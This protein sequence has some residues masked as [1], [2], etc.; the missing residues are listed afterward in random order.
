MR[1]AEKLETVEWDFAGAKT[2]DGPH[3]IHPYPAKFIPQIPKT[4]IKLFHPGDDSP[5]LDPFCGSG[6][7][8]VEAL[9]VGIPSIGIDLNPLA[10]L[11]AKVKTTPL[12]RVVVEVAR[13]VSGRARK[14]ISLHSVK[15][16]PIPRLDH[17][18]QKPVQ[19]ALAALISEINQVGPND[20]CDALKIALSS[21][22]V[23]VSNQESDTRYAAVEKSLDSE[24][25]LK[26]FERAAIAL[27][28]A[29][30]SMEDGLFPYTPS[31]RIITKDLLRLAPEDVGTGVGLV[32]TS[33]PYPNAYEYWL[34]HKYRMYW[35]GMNP[36]AVREREIGA[37]LHYFKK[38][39]QTE[40]D[41]ERQMGQCFKLLY[42]V[43]R[44]GA[45][46]CFIVG[47][48]IIHGREIDNEALLERA[49]Q[50]NG[51][52]KVGSVER[53]IALHRKSFNLAHGT[54]NREKIVVFAKE[55]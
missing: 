40:A 50:P 9:N 29:L 44:T 18:F 53:N 24:T 21:I 4:L 33:P 3:G 25:V 13:G 23:R 8:L 28:S 52:R 36:I 14:K 11:I 46:A 47:R 37:R 7:T 48:S 34:Y 16:P 38:R 55:A 43:M 31:T 42:Q 41:F 6:T 22:I 51:F 39:H 20:L 27:S 30:S 1:I 49:A 32:V 15:I 54:I 5:I 17:W 10:T 2:S 12:Q 26:S 35:L 45:F 19:E